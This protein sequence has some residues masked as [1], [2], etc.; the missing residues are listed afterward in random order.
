MV[1]K[2]PEFTDT[3]PNAFFCIIE[4]RFEL[5]NVT[6]SSTKFFNVLAALPAEVVSRLPVSYDS[7][8]Q[9][10][11]SLYDKSKPEL[12]NR[13][14]KNHSISGRPSL[15]L[16]E[17]IT[18]ADRT[19]I[20][21]VVRHQFIQALPP[22]ISPVIASQKDLSL[23]Q[24]GLLADELLPYFNSNTV[25]AVQPFRNFNMTNKDPSKTSYNRVP[26]TSNSSLP[27][28]IRP[29]SPDQRPRICRAHIYFGQTG[30][31]CKEWCKWP[32]KRNCSILPR[33]RPTS[34]A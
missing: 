28:N 24:L 20:G 33:S 32:D 29:F 22:S 4:A 15:Y 14:M 31:T 5:K 23:S 25:N 17:M 6:V 11:I 13:L 18:L 7:L 16:N 8:K 12:L 21:E 2:P 27:L 9:V 3:N 26:G 34:P 19:E 10:F 1:I 30:R